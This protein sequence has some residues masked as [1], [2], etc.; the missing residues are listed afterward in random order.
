VE[1]FEAKQGPQSA[2][3]I[4]VLDSLG[5]LLESGKRFPE[6]EVAFRRSIAIRE[7]T[8]GPVSAEMAPALDSLGRVLY[9]QKKFI[10]AE[11]VY[12]RAL[13][14]WEML[15]G[16][17]SALY[18][19]ALDNLAV[20]K[21]SLSKYEEA[22]PLYRTALEIREKLTVSSL[23]N[24]ALVEA[25]QKKFADAEPSYKVALAILERPGAPG[26]PIRAAVAPKKQAPRQP[27]NTPG[28]RKD[29]DRDGLLYSTLENYSELLS[30]TNRAAAARRMED[31]LKTMKP[32][33]APAVTGNP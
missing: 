23:N 19:N 14:V 29:P 32:A 8:N 2:Q 5:A 3:L 1:I 11:P 20:T 27:S 17:D 28:E 9:A 21:A 12:S 4:G 18:A 33:E 6:A 10:D 15:V 31:R 26:F 13:G 30:D 22:E 24:Y 7:R 25:A 16:T